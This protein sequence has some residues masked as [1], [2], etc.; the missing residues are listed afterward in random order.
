MGWNAIVA[1]CTLYMAAIRYLANGTTEGFPDGLFG[2][3]PVGKNKDCADSMPCTLY[4][5]VS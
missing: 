4:A 1:V 5:R 3:V 2:E